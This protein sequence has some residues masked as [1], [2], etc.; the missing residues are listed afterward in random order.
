MEKLIELTKI[1]HNARQRAK[2]L[3]LP[4]VGAFTPVEGWTVWQHYAPGAKLVDVRTRA[5]QHW[6]GRI[7]GAIEI[8]WQ[9]Y[10]GELPNPD[11][12]AQLERYVETESIVMFLCR[13]GTRSH[14]AACAAM[15]A[16]YGES[17]NILEGFEGG[18]DTATDQRGILGGWRLAGLPWH[19]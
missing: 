19:S 1:L 4:Y 6:V 11:F 8:E 18:I 14:K 9:S 13:S 2:M 5:E 17:Y 10:P 12:L 15:K 16:G 7:P 3:E